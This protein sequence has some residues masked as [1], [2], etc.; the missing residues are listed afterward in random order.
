MVRA[1]TN[2][3]RVLFRLTRWQV[4]TTTS[5]HQGLT[6]TDQPGQPCPTPPAW[7]RIKDFL[8]R[9]IIL[10]LMSSQQ[11]LLK[12][13]RWNAKIVYYFSNFGFCQIFTKSFVSGHN[14]LQEQVRGMGWK[15]W[16]RS[17]IPHSPSPLESPPLPLGGVAAKGR[18]SGNG[19]AST[20][21]SVCGDSAPDHVHYGSVTC[22]SCRAFFRRSVEL[23]QCKGPCMD[24]NTL[25]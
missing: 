4:P 3:Q 23:M 9:L 21:C 22:F 5:F 6:A 15:E 17:S 12:G 10:K 20:H 1:T 11:H 19:S 8:V 24:S 14:V 2:F 7:I 13:P 16:K 25:L 18:T